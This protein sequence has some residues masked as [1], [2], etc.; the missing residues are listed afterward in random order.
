M[1]K[2]EFKKLKKIL[3]PILLVLLS[4]LFVFA[5]VKI[6]SIKTKTI[7]SFEYSVGSIDEA[8]GMYKEDDQ[9]LYMKEAIEC[10]GLTIKPGFDASVSYQVFWYN[11]DALYFDCTEVYSSSY[12]LLPQEVPEFARYCRIVIYPS[13]LDDEGNDI[14]D[15]K[16]RFYETVSYA[17]ELSIKV[18]KVQKFELDNILDVSVEKISSNGINAT[19]DDGFVILK[20]TYLDALSSDGTLLNKSFT[21]ALNP[22][23]TEAFVVAKTPCSDVI[24]YNLK[25]KDRNMNGGMYIVFYNAEYRAMSAR[26]VGTIADTEVDISVP[27]GACYIAF[28]NWPLTGN[29]KEEA[30]FEVYC[31]LPRNEITEALYN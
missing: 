13:K 17:N 26:I 28:L 7:S 2:R 9:A 30:E 25:I 14:E 8:T 11:V 3:L 15:F 16:V 6:T 19:L 29:V 12:K 5:V 31:T 20:H 18:D 21:D 1:I 24:R 22:G 27:N 4:S 10:R 23:R